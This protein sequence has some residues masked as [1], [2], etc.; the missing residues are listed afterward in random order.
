MK[1]DR[2]NKLLKVILVFNIVLMVLV[3][4][5]FMQ[6]HSLQQQVDGAF[7]SIRGALEGQNKLET[8]LRSRKIIE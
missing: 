2:Q 4:M 5:L 6:I 3:I 7:S 1:K 8:D